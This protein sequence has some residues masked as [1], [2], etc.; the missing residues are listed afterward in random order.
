MTDDAILFGC[1]T[2]TVSAGAWQNNWFWHNYPISLLDDVISGEPLSPHPLG[3]SQVLGSYRTI[4]S[5][6]LTSSFGKKSIKFASAYASAYI[7]RE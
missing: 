4:C 3:H 7:S 2:V 5:L 6:S 1:F